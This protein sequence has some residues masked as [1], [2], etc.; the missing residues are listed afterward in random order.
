MTAKTSTYNAGKNIQYESNV[1]DALHLPLEAVNS[2]VADYWLGKTVPYPGGVR[3]EGS[4]IGKSSG[5][6]Y[7]KPHVVSS[8]LYDCRQVACWD[9][10][11]VIDY[12]VNHVYPGL[13]SVLPESRPLELL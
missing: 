6:W 13:C 11:K 10:H 12:A 4:L 3:E 1:V 7:Y 9:V 8:H 5:I 2:R